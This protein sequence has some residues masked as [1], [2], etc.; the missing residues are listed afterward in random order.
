MLGKLK[1]FF[2]LNHSTTTQDV[3][4]AQLLVESMNQ[5]LKVANESTVISERQAYLDDACNLLRELKQLVRM[6]PAIYITSLEAF[7]ASIQRVDAET[8]QLKSSAIIQSKEPKQA[9]HHN[10]KAVVDDIIQSHIKVINESIKL[11][12][13]SKNLDTK[14]SRIKV[15]RN[16]LNSAREQALKFKIDVDGFNEAEAIINEIETAIKNGA[17]TSGIILPDMP[18]YYSSPAR[19][20]LK[21]ATALKR[22]K[23]YIEAC[24]TL[25]KAYSSEGANDLMIEERLRLPMYLLLAGKNE[26]GWDEMNRGGPV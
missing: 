23:K 9:I 6:N 17:P 16:S 5:S 11:A 10:D 20:L 1:E 21:S 13:D 18:D 12:R 14:T 22:D 8:Q 19:E 24:E 7:E 4:K 26:D 2:G 15:A 25:I 3:K